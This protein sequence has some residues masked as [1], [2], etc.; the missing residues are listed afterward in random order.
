MP[1]D[2]QQAQE[3]HH[4]SCNTLAHCNCKQTL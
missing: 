2:K 4:L 3:D 1:L